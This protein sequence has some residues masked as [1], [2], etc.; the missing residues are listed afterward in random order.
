MN[1]LEIKQQKIYFQKRCRVYSLSE[2]SK[3]WQGEE[4]TFKATIY[5]ILKFKS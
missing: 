5:A 4:K 1:L 3:L 2:I